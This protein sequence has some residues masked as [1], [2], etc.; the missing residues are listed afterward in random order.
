[1]K[2]SKEEVKPEEV[3]IQTT[4]LED[5]IEEPQKTE[6]LYSDLKPEKEEEKL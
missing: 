3:F 1:V 2:P 6:D 5:K 4:S